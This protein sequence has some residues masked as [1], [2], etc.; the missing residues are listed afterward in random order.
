MSDES[1]NRRK[2]GK[3]EFIGDKHVNWLSANAI[4]IHETSLSGG[5][6]IFKSISPSGPSPNSKYVKIGLLSLLLRI[7]ISPHMEN[8]EWAQCIG[9]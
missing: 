7:F 8:V 9:D 3:F 2:N 6:R 1:S 4:G 5:R